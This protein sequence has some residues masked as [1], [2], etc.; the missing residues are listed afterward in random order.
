MSDATSL[1][2]EVLYLA[3]QDALHGPRLSGAQRT[4]IKETYKARAYFTVPNADFNQ[5]C[6]L[7]D[8]DPIAV[9]EAVAAQIKTA[10]TPEEL[11]GAKKRGKGAKL[12]S[13]QGTT[14]TIAEWAEQIGLNKAALI[15][16]L[17]SGWPVER[18][19]AEPLGKSGR[20]VVR[21]FAAPLGTGGG[22]SAQDRQNL[23]FP[24][25]VTQ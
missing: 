9:R 8:L 18:A 7:A 20:G 21:D 3:L 25:E 12:L 5:V 15:N 17:E 24:K 6:H 1:W 22:T 2:R 19:L 11:I 13:H 10:P 14:Q 23:S 4:K 16:R